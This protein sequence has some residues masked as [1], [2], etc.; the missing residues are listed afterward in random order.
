VA[1]AACTSMDGGDSGSAVPLPL[2]WGSGGSPSGW[3]V[4]EPR[5]LREVAARIR[6]LAVT[7]R[8]AEV[9]SEWHRPG[10][11]G[12]VRELGNETGQWATGRLVQHLHSQLRQGVTEFHGALV[13]G[14]PALAA[15]LERSASAYRTADQASAQ[16]ID[17]A[18]DAVPQTP[19]VV[20]PGDRAGAGVPPA[21]GEAGPGG[22]LDTGVPPASGEAGPGGS[23]DA[24]V[25]PASGEAGPGGSM[26]AGVPPASREAGPGGSMDAGVP[27]APS[28][29]G[30]DGR[31]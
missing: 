20:G 16:R 8:P 2:D 11:P 25:P 29:V 1:G 21:P 18:A 14:L 19:S 13:A 3:L 7:G 4:A 28:V 26:D 24:G 10:V 22:S 12:D 30:P 15:R 17:Q 31:F 6:R 5:A 9:G 27:S 23:L